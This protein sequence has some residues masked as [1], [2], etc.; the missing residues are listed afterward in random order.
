MT[1]FRL[2]SEIEAIEVI[3]VGRAI[4]D[5]PRLRK[6]YGSGHWRKLKGYALDGLE[7]GDVVEADLHTR[8]TGLAG[9]T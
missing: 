7:T 3:A 8:P 2:R 9:G 4:R 6:A 5:L 1:G